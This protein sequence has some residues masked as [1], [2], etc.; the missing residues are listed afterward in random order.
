MK[1]RVEA[2]N[3]GSVRTL[4]RIVLDVVDEACRARDN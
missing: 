1:G 4:S 2:Q 3:V